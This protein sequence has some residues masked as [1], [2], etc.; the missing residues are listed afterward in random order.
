MKRLLNTLSL[1]LKLF[2]VYTLLDFIRD[3]WEDFL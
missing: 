1:G 3:H 2:R